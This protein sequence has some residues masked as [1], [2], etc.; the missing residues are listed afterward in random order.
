M[1]YELDQLERSE[2]YKKCEKSGLIKYQIIF[3]KPLIEFFS[4]TQKNRKLFQVELN[5]F[6]QYPIALLYQMLLLLNRIGR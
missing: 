4:Y 5:H 3:R 1:R 2:T 6:F